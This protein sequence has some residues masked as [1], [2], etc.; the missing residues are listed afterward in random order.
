[1]VSGKVTDD[2][3]RIY[4]REAAAPASFRF[5]ARVARV[6]PD[7]IR[8][9]VPGYALTLEMIQII[10]GRYAQAGSRLYDLGCSLGASTLAMRD[11]VPGRNCRIVALDRSEAMLARCQERLPPAEKGDAPIDLLCMD[12]CDVKIRD[13]SVVVMNFTLQFIDT[14]QRLNLLRSIA[15]G[16][17]PGGVLI[18]SEKIHFEEAWENREH[19]ALHEAFKARQGYSR[20]EIARKRQALENILRPE[21]LAT[22]RRRLRDAGFTRQTLW[23]Q[24]VNFASLLAFVE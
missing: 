6:F 24:C 2:D 15:Q 4:L 3:D 5:D 16:L 19:Q 10:A 17:R 9:S 13:A 1:M 12:A 11:A 21:S 22:H 20:M 23:F 8:R 14:E 7:M 18:L